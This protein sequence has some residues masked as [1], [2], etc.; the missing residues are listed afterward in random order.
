MESVEKVA[1]AMGEADAD[2]PGADGPDAADA[3]A[4]AAIGMAHGAGE[5]EP[6]QA[7]PAP[8]PPISADQPEAMAALDAVIEAAPAETQKSPTGAVADAVSTAPASPATA[9]TS[10]PDPWAALLEV[11][12]SLLQCLA[13]ARSAPGA[14]P[15]APPFS[16]ERD[17]VTGQASVR[18]PWPDAA[19]LQKLAKAFEPWL[20]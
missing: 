20:R 10:A 11:A 17:P 3:E 6:A 1:G 19:L 18:L 13:S 7:T 8:R 9:T 15:G 2:G 14:A 4:A 16:I 5:A 12:A